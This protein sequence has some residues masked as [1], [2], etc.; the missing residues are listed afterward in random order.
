V[1]SHEYLQGRDYNSY[2]FLWEYLKVTSPKLMKRLHYQSNLKGIPK[3]KPCIVVIDEGDEVILSD[4]SD[5]YK[6]T[7]DEN[8]RVIC[9]TATADDGD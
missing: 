5:F 1:F 9:L 6:K 7:K 2:S 8:I 4:I 3:T